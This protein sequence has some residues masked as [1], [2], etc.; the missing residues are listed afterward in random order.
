MRKRCF[1]SAVNSSL[2]YTARLKIRTAPLVLVR[3]NDKASGRVLAL[4]LGLSE[5][6]VMSQF[7][8]RSLR[9]SLCV[10]TIMSE[11]ASGPSV[12]A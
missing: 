8:F 7:E 5:Y 6:G 10:A 11:W 12:S 2:V 3:S 9:K 4:W 1:T